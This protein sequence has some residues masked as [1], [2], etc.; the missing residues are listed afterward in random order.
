MKTPLIPWLSVSLPFLLSCCATSHDNYAD[1]NQLVTDFYAHVEAINDVEFESQVGESMAV[2]GLWGALENAHG[3]SAD[4]L[5]GATVSAFFGGLITAL[6]EGPRY[7]YE[8]HLLA[9][10]G[11]SVIVVLDYFPAEEG[12]CVRVRMANSVSVKATDAGFC[13]SDDE[14]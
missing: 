3:N 14:Y 13:Y 1:R 4:M 5:V 7:G 2:W 11:D 9:V 6:S 10:D 12:Q 8:Y